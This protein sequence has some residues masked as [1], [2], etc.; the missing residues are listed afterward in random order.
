MRKSLW[1]RIQYC[2]DQV[3]APVALTRLETIRIERVLDMLPKSATRVLEIGSRH[4][5]MTRSLA[6]I[7]EDV[8]ALDLE[9]PPFAMDHVTPV[10]GDVR[11]I[12]FPDNSFD[13]VVCTEVLEHVPEFAAGARE[14]RRVARSHI[15]VGVPYRQ[16]IRI[17]RTTCLACGKISPPWGHVNSFD[18]EK[19][20]QAFEGVQVTAIEYVGETRERT[21]LVSV[22]LQDIARN[23]YGIYYDEGMCTHC[24]SK[25]KRPS[26]GSLIRRT[27]GVL[28][29]RTQAL[30]S[31][32]A[33]SRPIWMLLLFEKHCS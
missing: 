23:P 8:T 7:F 17:G 13:C 6:E 26:R 24:G 14:I 4:G 9:K 11:N 25:L 27:A 32:L 31:A 19:I 5:A 2:V 22:W 12:Q 21:N 15:L 3:R 16:D 10:R 33:Q 1:S 29:L 30:Q 20:T 18:E 28:G